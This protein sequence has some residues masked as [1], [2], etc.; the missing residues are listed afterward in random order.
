[1][2]IR[3]ILIMDE[4]NLSKK[5]FCDRVRIYFFNEILET[6]NVSRSPVFDLL[7]VSSVFGL[8]DEIKNMIENHYF[9]PKLVWR[10]IVWKRAWALED[11]YWRIEKHLHRSLDLLSGVNPVT[12][13]L[14]W[15]LISDKYPK[16]MKD[17]EILA[18]IISHSS[19]LRDDDLKL[20]NQLGTTRMCTLCDRFE[21]EDARHFILI[22]PHFTRERNAMLLDIDSLSDG[23]QPKFFDDNVDMLHKLLGIPHSNVSGTQSEKILLIILR[24]VSSM[25]REN[26]KQKKDIG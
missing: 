22:C 11:L 3:T 4:E 6:E 1:M 2:F 23:T 13:Y 25:Y 7:N 16:Y 21:I 15:W 26:M 17:C 12:R 10:N 8:I 14:P 19:M 5:I 9:Y 18:K 24:T 20:K